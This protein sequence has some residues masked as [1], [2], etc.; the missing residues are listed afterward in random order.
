ML[1]GGRIEGATRDQ[2]AFALPHGVLDQGGGRQ[3]PLN[4]AWSGKAERLQAISTDHWSDVPSRAVH[5][6]C[7]LLVRYES[8]R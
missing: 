1:T 6:C 2:H 3:V 5:S 7:I 8:T 4:E